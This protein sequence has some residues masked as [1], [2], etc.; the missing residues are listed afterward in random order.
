MPESTSSS[1]SAPSP[2]ASTSSA[3]KPELDSTYYT[4]SNFFSILTGSAT[5][6]E[7]TEYFR[8]KDDINEKRDCQRCDE[9]KK[10]LF[11]YSP[12]IRFMKHNID[13][14]GPD[15]GSASINETNVRCRRCDTKQSG[16]FDPEYGI[17]ICANQLRNRGHLE[18]TLAHEMVHAYDHMRFKLDPYDLRH[19][20]CMEIRA[21]TLSGE[22]RW[23]REFFTRGQWGVTQ[24]LQ[25][26]VRRRATLS[27]AAR[28][29]CK[30]DVQAA[31]VVNEVWDS[32]FND[33]RP[34]D[35]IYK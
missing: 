8:A 7:R 31:H 5:N 10:W 26:C 3:S 6:H 20:A 16:G 27:V 30:D 1:A 4:W 34:F 15:D 13:L 18:D 2:S 23:T 35:E 11:K 28:P 12:I 24:Q 19:A 9:D 32:C 21:S 29:A 22:C 14:L 17:L 25:E 33:T